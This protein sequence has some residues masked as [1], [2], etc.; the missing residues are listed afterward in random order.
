MAPGNRAGHY[1][2]ATHVYFLLS[3]SFY[4]QNSQAALFV[5]LAQ[6][7]TV[8]SHKVVAGAAGWPYGWRDP[9]DILRQGSIYGCLCQA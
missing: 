1:Q 7:S 2:Q 5:F 8:S 3:S 9:G 6:L 4:L